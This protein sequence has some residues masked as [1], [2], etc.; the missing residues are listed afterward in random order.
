MSQNHR[1]GKGRDVRD[2]AQKWR[3]SPAPLKAD[4]A[5]KSQYRDARAPEG[6]R[7][8]IRAPGKPLGD[9]PAPVYSA[10]DAGTPGG[11]QGESP[12]M[13]LGGAPAPV[14]PAVA[15]SADIPQLDG[16]DPDP[17]NVCGPHSGYVFNA[18]ICKHET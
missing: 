5:S 10:S 15:E 1:T 2:I 4:S 6:L 8:E 11:P 14:D 7:G 17:D 18:V 3:G 9:A 13:I 12:G 16:A